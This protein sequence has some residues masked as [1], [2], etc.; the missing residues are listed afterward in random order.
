MKIPVKYKTLYQKL[1]YIQDKIQELQKLDNFDMDYMAE[2]QKEKIFY[3]NQLDN[4]CSFTDK[5]ETG[6]EI[7]LYH[8]EGKYK[9]FTN[10]LEY[11]FSWSNVS[12]VEE[13]CKKIVILINNNLDNQVYLNNLFETEVEELI[14]LVK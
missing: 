4:N 10:D 11:M 13:V 12:E 14:K 9:Y 7:G 6:L 5:V 1:I 8:S 2:L 3:E